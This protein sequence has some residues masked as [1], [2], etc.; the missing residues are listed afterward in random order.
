MRTGWLTRREFLKAAAGTAGLLVSTIDLGRWPVSHAATMNPLGGWSGGPGQA[1]YR[2]DGLAKVTGQRIYARD[3]QPIDLPNWPA[4]YR[5]AL[6]VY[7]PF[8]GHIFDGLD[9][10]QLP[11]E[12][13]PIV[14]ITAADL[15]RDSIG[16]AEEDY[17]EGEYLVQAGKPPSYLGQALA[18]LLY[19]ELTA[20]YEAKEQIVSN[21]KAIR[22]GK[23]VPLPEPTSYKPETSI[24]HALTREGEQR[25]AQTIE[26]P[27]HPAEPGATNEKAMEIVNMIGET[28]KSPDLDV[29]NQTYET[30]VVDPM[31]MEPETGL[32]WFDREAKTLRM[33]IGTQSPGYDVD[34]ARAL[35]APNECPIEIDD[36]HLYAAYPGGG[37]GGRDTSILCLYLALAA[38]YSDKPIRISNDRFQQFQSGI[39]RHASRVEL[40]LGVSNAN[41][42]EIFRNHSVLDGGGRRNVSVYVANV[43]GILGT[44]VYRAPLADIW[45]RA[46]RTVSQVAGSMRGFGS[47]QSTFAVESMVDEVALARGLDPLEF[48]KI[49]LLRPGD[50]IVTGA[51]RTPPGLGEICDKALAHPLWTNRNADQKRLSSEDERYGVGAALAMKNFGSGADA[52]MSQ[53][54][55]GPDGR[56]SVITHHVDMGQGAATAHALATSKAI[57]RNADEVDTGRTDI[58][59]ELQLVGG[60]DKQ[61]E[62]PRWT[63]IVWN[64]TK[65]T[66]GVGRWLHAT[67]QAADILLKT[68]ILPA[69]RSIW[70]TMADRIDIADVSWSEGQLTSAGFAPIPFSAI[71]AKLYEKKLATSAMVHGFFSGRWIE[72]DYTVDGITNRWKI[73]A[74]A[75]Q[76]G[77]MPAY[78][79]V[80]R[81]NPLLFTTESMWEENGQSFAAGGALAAVK[82]NRKT[83]VVRLIRGVHVLAPGTIIQRDLVEGQMDG[84]WAMGIGHTLLE[85]LPTDAD[86]AANGK[87][88]LDRY[89]VALSADCAIHDVEKIFIPPDPADSIPRGIAELVMITV[90]PAISNAVMHAIGHRFR[91]LPITP[92]KVR[93]VW[94]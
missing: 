27:V 13:Q 26:G 63:P 60:F 24:V 22:V 67:E 89:H 64:S 78:E 10:D 50:T 45:S 23:D 34:A 77:D 36:V 80:D 3:F 79:L 38:A 15:A 37:F 43:T 84:G 82:V 5:H 29:Y 25:F 91:S 73:D 76:R 30:P 75:I 35:F 87:W 74:L 93:A 14:T 68:S 70:G 66:A 9:L 85:G 48:R 56:L 2:I 32:A 21:G 65:A 7:A 17:P 11:K 62:N 54:H 49:N 31:F 94:N 83:G 6:V 86:G 18:I 40:T 33:L 90:G 16:I 20:Y 52:V 47:F 69:A 8:V 4:K 72:A 44:G 53:V 46:Q 12:L 28:L 57:G 1:R 88:N 42:I 71:A 61:P 19:D 81:K 92:D 39:K 51:P 41:L 59:R 58:F 55:I